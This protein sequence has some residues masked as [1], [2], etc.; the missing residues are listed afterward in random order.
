MS[1]YPPGVSGNEPEITGIWPCRLCGGAGYDE[2]EDGKH[3][4]K[5]CK[6]DGIEPEEPPYC[7][8]CDNEYWTNLYENKHTSIIV[9]NLCGEIN[10][11]D[12]WDEY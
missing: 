6:G 2:D 4:C 10:N 7:L 3:T 8:N 5:Y 9:C 11:P 12:E 1:N